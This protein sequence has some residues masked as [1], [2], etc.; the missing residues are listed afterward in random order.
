M[1]FSWTNVLQLYARYKKEF[2]K[3]KALYWRCVNPGYMYIRLLHLL[4]FCV[5]ESHI[6]LVHKSI[7]LGYHS[8]FFPILS[9]E[10]N[11]HV[12][13]WIFSPKRTNYLSRSTGSSVTSN[14]AAD[15]TLFCTVFVGA[16]C[17]QWVR[18][19]FCCVGKSEFDSSFSNPC[20][21]L[22]LSSSAIC[23]G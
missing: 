13:Y 8:N 11:V 16:C 1:L 17:W 14:L 19:Y 2:V 5:S 18:L 21:T 22:P 15:I 23:C 4:V 10:S 6:M 7:Y 9:T 12:S 3:V 20:V